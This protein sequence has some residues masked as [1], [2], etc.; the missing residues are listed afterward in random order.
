M[1]VRA[2]SSNTNEADSRPQFV[3]V[4]SGHVYSDD[5]ADFIVMHCTAQ[6][7]PKPQITWTFN[8]QP[9]HETE[10]IHIYDNGTLLIHQ[11]IEEDEGTYKCEATNYLGSVSTVANYKINGE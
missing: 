3:Q 11:P 1:I 8:D 10:H 4:P 7:A 5:H 9:L 2:S 6:G